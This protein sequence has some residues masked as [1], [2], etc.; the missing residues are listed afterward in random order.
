M[1]T[2]LLLQN[3]R[4]HGLGDI[5]DGPWITV[6]KTIT[7]FQLPEDFNKEGFF[8][9]VQSIN[10][11]CSLKEDKIFQN[12]PTIVRQGKYQK[13]VRPEK[14][15]IAFAIF[16]AQPDMVRDLAKITW[17]LYEADRV[18]VGR[19]LDYSRWVNFIE[20]ASSTRWS[21]VSERIIQLAEEHPHL[22]SDQL[23]RELITLKKTDR[24]EEDLMKSLS[25]WL[26][27]LKSNLSQESTDLI[28]ELLF[29]VNRQK[30]FKVAKGLVR[31]KLPHFYL[32]EKNADVEKLADH[33]S[34]VEK[35]GN[36]P[37]VLLVDEQSLDLTAL[38]KREWR[39]SAADLSQTYQILYMLEGDISDLPNDSRVVTSADLAGCQ[40]A[41]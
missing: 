38:E 12:Y 40:P 33:L 36:S 6:D 37:P 17:H 24:V 13:R 31:K 15:T 32:A 23:K 34:S 16:I 29:D 21:E 41:K 7:Y 1:I 3:I 35:K 18:E 20:I 30:D 2:P 9:T 19:R 10:P 4:V 28:D 5:V 11:L 14:R 26:Q 27:G 22:L 8:R 25:G 39:Q